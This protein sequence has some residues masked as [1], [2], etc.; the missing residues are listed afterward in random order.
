M[1]GKLSYWGGQGF[2]PW[3]YLNASV[4]NAQNNFGRSS[5]QVLDWN[6]ENIISYSDIINNHNFTVLLGQ[7]AYSAGNVKGSGLNFFNLPITHYQDASFNF[8]IPAADRTTWAYEGNFHRVMSLF[9]RVIYDYD[10][11]YM[12]T[13]IIRR[14]GS[15]R[16]GVHNRFGIFPSFSLGW[17]VSRENFWVENRFV[18]RLR[19]RGGYGVTGNDA[20]PDFGFLSLMGGGRNYTFGRAGND[21]TIGYSPNA[22]DNPDLRWEET[23]Q[24]NIGFDAQILTNFNL[25]VDL[26]RKQTT[27]ILQHIDLPGYVGATGNPLGNVA[28]MK[29]QGIEVELGF[30][31]KFGELNVSAIGN[32][33]YLHNE[34]TYLGQGIEFITAGVAGFQ[35]MGPI[36]R[37]EI[38]HPHNAFFGFQTNGIFQNLAEVNAYTN[39]AGIVI[40]PN[41]KPGDFR[42]LDYN[43]D[44]MITD[45]DKVFLGS[46]LP[47]YTFGFTLNL[48]YKGFDFL[49]FAQ[50]F[51]GNKIFQGLRRLD[52][53]NANYTTEALSRWRG[54]G[55]SNTFPRLIGS[56][57]NRNFTR[58]SDFYLEDGDFLRLRTLQIGYTLP[59]SLTRA[60]G[61]NSLRV[62]VSGENLFTLTNYTGYDPEI[63]GNVLGIDRGYYPQARSF[64]VGAN[65]RF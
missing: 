65:V 53:A 12:F 26:Y 9:A 10:E 8:A 33:S 11:K 24:T 45:L 15:S 23:A 14:D 52:I 60:V 51:A 64:M 2:T 25:V 36:T 20:I 44:G 59:G 47:K 55:T 31:R 3:Y 30:R 48:E 6:L 22:P 32:F 18:N 56:D 13:G 37:T 19:I 62:F 7:G 42:W 58:P 38:G 16:F 57:P 27:G 29:N 17:N 41:A 5:H 40:Q 61:A 4:N 63:G 1:G 28:D 35:S 49:M 39:S 43:D 54:E 34:V 21:I 46:P 50:G